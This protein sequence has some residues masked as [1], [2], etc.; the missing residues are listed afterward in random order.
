MG[1]EMVRHKKG[2]SV[3]NIIIFVIVLFSIALL[4]PIGQEIFDEMN[5]D[6]QNSPDIN[7][8]VKEQTDALYNRYSTFFDALFIFIFILMWI[9]ILVASLMAQEHPVIFVV[10]LVL[11]LFIVYT[12]YE[13]SNFY[14]DY[15]T[16]DEISYR[17]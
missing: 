2:F 11:M 15:N 6:I 3:L 5:Q 1:L 14:N 4:I 12:G 16:D 9:F 8:D 7:Q 17:K 10:S 13:F